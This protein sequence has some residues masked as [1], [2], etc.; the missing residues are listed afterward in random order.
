MERTSIKFPEVSSL[1]MKHFDA[2]RADTSVLRDLVYKIRYQIYCIENAF[3][4]PAQNPGGREIDADDDRAAHML[5][6]HRKSGEAAGTARVIFPDYRRVLPI[7][8]ILDPEGRRLFGRLPADSMGEV[9]RFAVSKAFRRRRGE[10]HY[11]DISVNAL[12][13]PTEQRVMPFITFGL[14]RSVVSVCLQGGL[15]HIA[16]VMEPPLVRLLTRFGLDF[17]PVGGLVEYHGQR[18]PCVARLHDLIDRVREESNSL[19][20]YTKDEIS[21]YVGPVS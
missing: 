20:L 19:W 6:I 2:I 21:R 9:S 1:Y 13:V 12:G 16:A 10:D 8:R 15:I 3:E 7:E 5:L 14:L 17:H 18:Q 4:D 11:A